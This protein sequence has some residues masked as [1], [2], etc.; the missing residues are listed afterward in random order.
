MDILVQTRDDHP[1]FI[2]LFEGVISTETIT[3]DYGIFSKTV[4]MRVTLKPGIDAQWLIDRIN[5]NTV[6]PATAWIEKE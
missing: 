1:E 3:T 4:T 5:K 2:F 6:W